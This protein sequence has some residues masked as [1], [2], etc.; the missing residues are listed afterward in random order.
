MQTRE[1]KRLAKQ[2]VW[3][4]SRGMQPKQDAKAACLK[5]ATRVHG[6]NQKRAKKI[7]ESFFGYIDPNGYDRKDFGES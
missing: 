6:P 4:A 7:A 1:E 5:R 3:R 2:T